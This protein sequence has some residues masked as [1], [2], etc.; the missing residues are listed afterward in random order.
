[1]IYKNVLKQIMKIPIIFVTIIQEVVFLHQILGTVLTLL[2]LEDGRCWQVYGPVSKVTQMSVALSIGFM[3]YFMLKKKTF[4]IFRWLAV[5]QFESTDARRA[6]PCF[7]EP[8][9]KATFAISLGHL[10]HLTA[11]SNMPL[12]DTKPM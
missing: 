8:A 10:K 7:D 2:S 4:V 11:V 3:C 6:F 12:K 5:T 1:M 9:L